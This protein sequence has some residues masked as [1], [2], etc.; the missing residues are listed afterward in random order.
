MDRQ[1]VI[2]GC[3]VRDPFFS[4]TGP[5]TADRLTEAVNTGRVVVERCTVTLTP[6]GLRIEPRETSTPGA[7][8]RLHALAT[9]GVPVDL[10]DGYMHGFGA[11]AYTAHEIAVAAL[12]PCPRCVTARAGDA[13]GR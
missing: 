2:D 11:A 3:E 12:G 9:S 7:V 5:S 1:F 6:D 13:T 8:E 4:L 10:G